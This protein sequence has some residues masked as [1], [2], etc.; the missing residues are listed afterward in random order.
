MGHSV[1]VASLAS[2]VPE[3]GP[4]QVLWFTTGAMLVYTATMNAVLH[5]AIKVGRCSAIGIAAGTSL[6]FVAYLLFVNTL[7]GT[8]RTL[9]TAMLAFWSV[10]LLL[11]GTAGI[12]AMRWAR[13]QPMPTDKDRKQ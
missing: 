9:A 8:G 6:L 12:A 11:L 13:T 4:L 2:R 7:P 3:Y 10:N 1:A 5:R